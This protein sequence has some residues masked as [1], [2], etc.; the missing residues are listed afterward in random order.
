MTAEALPAATGITVETSRRSR[1]TEWRLLASSTHRVQHLHS[2][3]SPHSAQPLASNK[4]S[5]SKH[6]WVT[7]STGLYNLT[8]TS[9]QGHTAPPS[10][11]PGSDQISTLQWFPSFARI[12]ATWPVK[13]QTVGLQPKGFWLCRWDP[14]IWI[15][16]KLSSDILLLV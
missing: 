4:S 11:S 5:S 13:T 8:E 16:N 15:C 1:E 12:S 10:A 2:V 14:R 9:H 3:S 6:C 7:S